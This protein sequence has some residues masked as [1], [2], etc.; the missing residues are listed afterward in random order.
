[1]REDWDISKI[2][3]VLPQ[4]YPF[5]FIDRVLEVNKEEG[6][7]VCLKNVT[8]NEHFFS[9]HFPNKPVMPGVLIIETM[10]QASI[11]LFSVLKPEIACKKPDYFIGKVEAKFNRPVTAGDQ[12][13]IKVQKEKILKNG[14]IVEAFA[15]VN[16]EVVAKAKIIFAVVLKNE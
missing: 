13:I 16:H 9:G 7:V 4:R 14:G 15:K 6:W 11:I 2:E 5:L 1:M 10:A 3:R 12:L 8:I